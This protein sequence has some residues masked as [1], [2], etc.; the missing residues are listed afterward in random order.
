[1]T[2]ACSAS[3]YVANA[4]VSRSDFTRDGV[5]DAPVCVTGFRSARQ[6]TNKRIQAPMKRRQVTFIV[7]LHGRFEAPTEATDHVLEPGDGVPALGVTWQHQEPFA[8]AKGTRKKPSPR[9]PGLIGN[10]CRRSRAPLRR[11]CS[12]SRDV[13]DRPRRKCLRLE[14][15]PGSVA[16]QKRERH[17][18]RSAHVI[19]QTTEDVAQIGSGAPP[20]AASCRASARESSADTLSTAV[21]SER[22][23]DIEAEQF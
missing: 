20:C 18:E 4:A 13:G 12:E 7:Q 23:K 2:S 6:P 15:P 19:Q 1:M 3:L 9:R 21:E 22:T 10:I 16:R 14:T 17:T 8:V 5:Q 11:G